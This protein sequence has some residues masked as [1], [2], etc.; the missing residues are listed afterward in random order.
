MPGGLAALLR[1]GRGF[2]ERAR[3]RPGGAFIPVKR[4]TWPIETSWGKVVDMP[5][6]KNPSRR[7]IVRLA[8]ESDGDVRVLRAPNGDWLAWPANEALHVDVASTLG[9]DFR[10]R[11]ALSRNSYLIDPAYFEGAGNIGDAVKRLGEDL[12]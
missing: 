10:N 5:I 9:L 12:D 2:A 4:E 8:R 3:A 1:H 6:Y 11:E 7:E